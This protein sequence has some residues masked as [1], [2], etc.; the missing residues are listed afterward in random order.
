[1]SKWLMA[2]EYESF[3]DATRAGR[4]SEWWKKYL[5]IIPFEEHKLL[6]C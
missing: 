3:D 6:M 2:V 4:G 5:P 1:M